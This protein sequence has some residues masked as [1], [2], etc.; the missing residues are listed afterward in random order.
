MKPMRNNNPYKKKSAFFDYFLKQSGEDFLMKENMVNLKRRS[1]MFFRDMANGSFDIE[2]HGQ[3]ISNDYL[4]NIML[5][6]AMIKVKYYSIHCHFSGT[7]LQ[8]HPEY[9]SDDVQSA[10]KADY[11]SLTAYTII[12][13]G[14]LNLI[15]TRNLGYLAMIANQMRYFKYSL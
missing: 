9:N 15:Q 6:E 2:K 7:V 14:L 8:D 5:K 12:R 13:D 11:D 4:L 3:Y 10:I 1:T